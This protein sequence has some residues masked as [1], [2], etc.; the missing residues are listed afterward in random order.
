VIGKSD[1]ILQEAFN[2]YHDRSS[3][4]AQSA[5]VTIRSRLL[6]SNSSHCRFSRRSTIIIISGLPFRESESVMLPVLENL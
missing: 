1:R 4:Q 6:T 2:Q 3:M 5:P